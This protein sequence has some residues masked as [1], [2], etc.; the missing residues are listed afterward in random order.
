M[1][2]NIMAPGR[3]GVVRPE[4]LAHTWDAVW[5]GARDAKTIAACLE[6][7]G[8]SLTL[9]SV[10]KLISLAVAAGILRQTGNTKAARYTPG[11]RPKE[12][13]K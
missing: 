13:T 10:R 4:L 6:A 5:L 1:K 3:Q 8:H 2:A 7:A 9:V 11:K 12:P